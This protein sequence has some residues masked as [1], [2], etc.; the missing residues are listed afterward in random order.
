MEWS[1]DSA[2][3]VIRRF[4]EKYGGMHLREDCYSHLL[5]SEFRAAFGDRFMTGFAFGATKVLRAQREDLQK[6][7][8]HGFKGNASEFYPDLVALP[9]ELTQ[10]GTNRING[11]DHISGHPPVALFEWKFLSTFRNMS[12]N[13]ARLDAKKLQLIGEYLD[14]E[15]GTRP[16]LMQCF[17]WFK[18]EGAERCRSRVERWFSERFLGEIPNVRSYF[19]SLDE[20][21]S[22]VEI[23]RIGTGA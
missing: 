10:M 3:D 13:H 22:G 15:E 18:P 5:F 17:F 1:E 21:Q 2:V 23:H 4:T 14:S 16:L 8:E 6:P 12:R 11:I 20:D 9:K 19:I 7:A